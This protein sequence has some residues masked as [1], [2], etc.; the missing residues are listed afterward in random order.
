M[1]DDR[2][3]IVRYLLHLWA[4]PREDLIKSA[5]ERKYC[6][7]KVDVQSYDRKSQCVDNVH[8]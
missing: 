5:P 6:L 3:N 1:G 8:G 7:S 2:V 4:R